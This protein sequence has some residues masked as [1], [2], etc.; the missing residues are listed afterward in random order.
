MPA[1]SF[2]CIGRVFTVLAEFVPYWP[3]H[4]YDASR[5]CDTN[6]ILMRLINNI[7]YIASHSGTIKEYR[8]ISFVSN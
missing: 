7:N 2:S 5:F 1:H 4:Q 6:A 8:I 3:S